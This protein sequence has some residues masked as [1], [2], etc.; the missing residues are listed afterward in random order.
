MLRSLLKWN[1]PPMLC[2]RTAKSWEARK[3]C[4]AR[5]WGEVA[6]NW[7]RG[8]VTEG[9]AGLQVGLVSSLQTLAE[10]VAVLATGTWSV[11]IWTFVGLTPLP[12]VEASDFKV[13]K[14]ACVGTEMI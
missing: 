14:P 9:P 8:I 10:L 13:S 2:F 11:R 1:R 12:V 3:R 6:R 7:P 4:V 5:N